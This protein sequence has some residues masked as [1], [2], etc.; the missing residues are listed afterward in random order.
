MIRFIFI[1]LLMLCLGS[2]ATPMT[3]QTA[4]YRLMHQGNA[5]FRAGQYDRAEKYYLLVLKSQPHNSRAH[6][7]LADTYLAKGN[8]GAADSLYNIVTQSEKNKQVRSMAWHNRGYICQTAAL[9]DAQKQQQLLRQAIEHYKQALR[10]NPNDND[11]RYNLAL[12]QRQLKKGNSQSQQQQQEQQQKQENQPDNDKQKQQQSQSQTNN[13]RQDDDRQQTEQY[14]NLA[15]QAE[16]RALEKLKSM[17]PRQKS[18]D[19]N[20]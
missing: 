20:W 14:L 17:Q 6:F 19:K 13:P 2:I 15:R 3:A 7:N 8:P 9:H 1:S 5:L 18:L 4:T 16:R 10:L 11:T 12:C